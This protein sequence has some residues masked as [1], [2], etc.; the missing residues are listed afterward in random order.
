MLYIL[1]QIPAP[2]NMLHLRRDEKTAPRTQ[3][4]GADLLFTVLSHT[5]REHTS[6]VYPAGS[7]RGMPAI[8]W[9]WA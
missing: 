8:S 3:M 1:A 2:V 4:R 6:S 5:I 9:A 7:S